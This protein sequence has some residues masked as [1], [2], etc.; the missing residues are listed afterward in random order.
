MLFKLK[1]IKTQIAPSGNGEASLDFLRVALPRK[2]GVRS[3]S[4][5]HKLG[6][7][8]LYVIVKRNRG[9]MRAIL[10]ELLVHAGCAN[11]RGEECF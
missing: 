1:Q 10:F 4:I 2:E 7:K 9:G 6:Y 5:A 11:L 8:I 3:G